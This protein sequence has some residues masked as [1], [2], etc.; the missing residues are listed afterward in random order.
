V[1]TCPANSKKG[2][3]QTFVEVCAVPFLLRHIVIFFVCGWI[4]SV[5]RWFLPDF[6]TCS[7]FGVFLW[8]E[9]AAIL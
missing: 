3:A 4:L 8:Q 1:E 9:W 7:T 5:C 2:T 6:K